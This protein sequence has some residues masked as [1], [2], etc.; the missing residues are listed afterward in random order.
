MD[1]MGYGDVGC[2]GFNVY[3]TPRLDQM[4]KEGIRF[5]DFHVAASMCSPS[6]AAL[7]TGCYPKRIGLES[8]FRYWVLCPG[9]PIGLNPKEITL[10]EVLKMYGYTTKIVGKWHLGDQP[11]FLP[12]YHGFDSFFGLPYSNDMNPL[13]PNNKEYDF[14]PLPLMRNE[15]IIETEPVQRHLAERYLQECLDFIRENKDQP[16]F[17]YLSHFYVH[18]PI[19]PPQAYLEKSKGDL[20]KAAVMHIDEHVGQ[21]LKTLKEMK[22]DNKTLVIFTSDN[23][24]GGGHNGPLRG[25]KGS[26][27]EGGFRVPC[28]MRWLGKIPGGME[29]GEFA[30]SMDIMPT[31]ALL[32]GIKPVG[33]GIIDG[34]DI[35]ELMFAN[36]KAK[37]KY[38]AFCYYSGPNLQA[39]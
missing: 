3:K 22:I 4:A 18:N 6:R 2:Y 36:P 24:N 7:M 5:T 39:V 14:P 10:A 25:G 33:N 38:K 16:F 26:S 9:E 30:T 15:Q 1:D 17:L 23:G 31:V 20:Y 35:R 12:T 19:Q 11:E 13:N 32:A 34:K 8:G 27:Y 37:S 28:I 21:I 29:C